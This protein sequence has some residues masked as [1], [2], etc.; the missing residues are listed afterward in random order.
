MKDLRSKSETN[1]TYSEVAYDLDLPDDNFTERYLRR[2][3]R[4]YMK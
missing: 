1:V 4:K 3:P 2:A